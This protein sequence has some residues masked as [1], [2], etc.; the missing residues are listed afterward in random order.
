M[1]ILGAALR[2]ELAAGL[3][4]TAI[5]RELRAL[6]RAV[7]KLESAVRSNGRARRRPGPGRA[8][9]LSPARRAAL[10][11]QGQYMGYL[12]NLRPRQKAAVKKMKSTK[13]F[14][15]AIK[16]AKKLGGR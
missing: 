12:R 15:A 3:G 16:L 2:R 8:L 5:R 11:L 10:K 13:G 14:S 1:A 4:L 7:R 9:T 6:S